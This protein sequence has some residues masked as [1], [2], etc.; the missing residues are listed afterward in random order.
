MAGTRRSRKQTN[1]KKTSNAP[2]LSRA[3]KVAA[4]KSTIKASN[5]V[6]KYAAKSLRALFG[7]P[8]YSKLLKKAAGRDPMIRKKLDPVSRRP[9]GREEKP[10]SAGRR[11]SIS[12]KESIRRATR[13][14]R[15]SNKRR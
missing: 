11:G 15:S 14:N 4:V 9:E 3:Q 7:T 5:L 13:V 2:L 1:T 12:A 8:D 6:N 10:Q